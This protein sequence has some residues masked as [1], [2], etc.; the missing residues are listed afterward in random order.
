MSF[1][2]LSRVATY[3]AVFISAALF[4]S[5]LGAQSSGA[6]DCGNGSYC[7]RGNACLMGGLCGRIVDAVPVIV[8]TSFGTWCDPGFR[9]SKLTPGKCVPGS[10]T[11]C[12]PTVICSCEFPSGCVVVAPQRTQQIR[13][14]VMPAHGGRSWRASP[15]LESREGWWPSAWPSAE[16]SATP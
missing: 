5:Q 9:E 10:Y 4:T 8:R 2:S 15:H 3:V 13:R 14:D 1:V 7:P 12:S 16:A 11:A 6:V